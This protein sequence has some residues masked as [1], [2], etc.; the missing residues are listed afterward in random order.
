[1]GLM[2]VAGQI[3]RIPPLHTVLR[4]VAP[5]MAFRVALRTVFLHTVLLMVARTVVLDLHT[6]FLH[7]VALRTVVHHTGALYYLKYRPHQVAQR[8]YPRELQ[9]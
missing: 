4:Q 1:M 7:I 5:H 3:L 6:A 8:L 2:V 9:H